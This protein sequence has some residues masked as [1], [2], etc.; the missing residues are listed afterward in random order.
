MKI[1]I[2]RTDKIGDVVLTLPLA[3]IIKAKYP[4]AYIYFLGSSYTEAIVSKSKY[5]DEFLDW[6]E[7]KVSGAL[8]AADYIIH[9]FPNKAVANLAKKKGIDTRIGTSHRIFHLWNCNKLVNFTRKNSPLHEAQLNTKLLAPFGISDIYSKQEL[10]NFTG[11]QKS[12]KKTEALSTDK[13]N[14]IFHTK[15]KGSALE[16]P[17]EKYYET[18]KALPEGKFQI[19][20]SGTSAEGA[21]IR[22]ELSAL[23]KLENVTDI[24][25]KFTLEEFITFIEQCDGLLACS[26]GPLHI[27]SAADIQ[28]LGLYPSQRPM[29][30]GRWGPLG[31]RSQYLE[32]PNPKSEGDLEIKTSEV[33]RIV[34]SWKK[35]TKTA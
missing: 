10:S 8:P 2:S 4:Y 24:T 3:G 25:G 7:I 11:W 30:A 33:V 5:I 13:L 6:G 23:F 1:I 18:I 16:W 22:S 35:L 15:S 27:A 9:V 31:S 26:T 32:D 19:F 34:S 12:Y 29:D 21:I 28:C 14:I 17:L 20:V